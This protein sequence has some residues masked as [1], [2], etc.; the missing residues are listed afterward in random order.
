MNTAYELLRAWAVM[1]D[2]RISMDDITFGDDGGFP[3]LNAKGWDIK[4]VCLFL[5]PRRL[6]AVMQQ[7]F[8]G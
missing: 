6:Q 2:V 8:A 5:A 1:H 3:T 4:L 7:F